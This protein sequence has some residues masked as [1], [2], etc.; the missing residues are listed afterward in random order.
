MII[1]LGAFFIWSNSLSEEE[2]NNVINL[3][4]EIDELSDYKLENDLQL[5]KAKAKLDT[6]IR[7][8]DELNL[9]EKMKV[10]K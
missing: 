9:R 8:Y 3:S 1:C 10:E 6:V 7:K 5:Q 4:I 2:I